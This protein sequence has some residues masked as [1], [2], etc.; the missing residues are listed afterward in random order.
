MR[1]PREH[2]GDTRY[3]GYRAPEYTSWVQMIQRCY[4]PRAG[5]YERYGGRGI[6]VCDR[7]HNSY[8]AFLQDMGRKPG[9]SYSIERVNNDGNYEPS[10]CVWAT[11]KQQGRNRSSNN[12]IRVGR[13]Q[14]CITD[15]AADAGC[16]PSAI[17]GRLH[18]G[19]SPEEATSLPPKPMPPFL[20]TVCGVTKNVTAW[21]KQSGIP[22]MTLRHRILTGWSPEDAISVPPGDRGTGRKASLLYT[23]GGV[24]KPLL[25]WARERGIGQSTLYARLEDGWGF[26]RALGPVARRSPR[27]KR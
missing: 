19:W 22:V 14:K 12:L 5:G 27:T 4:N 24:T 20:V 3:E 7:W 16:Y 13:K 25:H 21:S 18:R 6:T 23:I 11:K 8:A 26:E 2:H 1:R 9:P 15:W 10:N 17:A